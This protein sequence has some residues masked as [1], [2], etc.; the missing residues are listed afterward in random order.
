[1]VYALSQTHACCK[2]PLYVAS[3]T[4]ENMHAI[5]TYSVHVIYK[6]TVPTMYLYILHVVFSIHIDL[7]SS[8]IA[9]NNI[10][11]YCMHSLTEVKVGFTRH[12]PFGSIS[13]LA[14]VQ[15]IYKC[16]CTMYMY[17][18]ILLTVQSYMLHV[19]VCTELPCTSCG[20]VNVNE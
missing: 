1:M 11:S 9:A 14:I 8:K 5:T 18:Y 3:V 2:T 7:D 17:L 19:H 10:R 6:C 4:T 13:K 12:P 16:M 20:K 15:Y